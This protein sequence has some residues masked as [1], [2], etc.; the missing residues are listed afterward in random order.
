MYRTCERFVS[1]AIDQ[2]TFIVQAGRDWRAMIG[3]SPGELD[4]L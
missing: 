2:P 1:G 4:K 3:T